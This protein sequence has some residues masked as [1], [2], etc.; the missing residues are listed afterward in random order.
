MTHKIWKDKTVEERAAEL[1]KLIKG[2]SEYV[3]DSI[4]DSELFADISDHYESAEAMLR[5]AVTAYLDLLP[6]EDV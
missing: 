4:E 1:R 6:E 5:D 2:V 3:D